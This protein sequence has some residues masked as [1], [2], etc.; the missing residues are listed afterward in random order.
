MTDEEKCP[1]CGKG[2][3]GKLGPF[4]YVSHLT[5]VRQ[6]SERLAKCS[7]QKYGLASAAKRGMTAVERAERAEADVDR[8]DAALKKAERRAERAE[9]EC[10]RLARIY[11]IDT[12]RAKAEVDRLQA[13]VERLKWMLEESIED[14]WGGFARMDEKE[15]APWLADLARR[16]EE[17]HRG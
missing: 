8:M 11:D 7:S 1:V 4:T 17:A 6:L 15:R 13:E 12:K 10:D 3:Y 14:A 9:A 5:C 2:E 16:Y